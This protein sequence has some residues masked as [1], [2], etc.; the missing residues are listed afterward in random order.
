MSAEKE[1][2]CKRCKRLLK[3]PFYATLG[4][5]K[6]C[7]AYLGIVIPSQ[8]KKEKK[9]KFKI[10]SRRATGMVVEKNKV[11]SPLQLKIQFKENGNDSNSNSR[12]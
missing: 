9:K 12:N 4:V 5:G 8:P 10:R 3:N 2:H 7:A 1:V 6:I 11:D